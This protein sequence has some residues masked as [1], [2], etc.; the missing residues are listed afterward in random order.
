M[1]SLHAL[2]TT[3]KDVQN[4]RRF[5][6]TTFAMRMGQL[7]R[8]CERALLRS[9]V[10]G[11]QFQTDGNERNMGNTHRA[12]REHAQGTSYNVCDSVYVSLRQI[13]SRAYLV[14]SP[15]SKCLPFPTRS[16]RKRSRESYQTACSRV[17]AQQ[18]FND[19]VNFWRQSLLSGEAAQKK[20]EYPPNSASGFRYLV[21]KAP[22]FARN[23]WWARCTKNQVQPR[24]R[25]F[26]K[27]R[28]IEINEP[29]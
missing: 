17:P 14:L 13:E 28:G 23:V 18:E 4:V 22:V 7:L 1:K 25:V 29:R 3:S 9:M 2:A 5:T 21:R 11:T 26:L 6:A 8:F 10:N 20:Y 15:Q 12:K 19:A 27:Q 16:P 24:L